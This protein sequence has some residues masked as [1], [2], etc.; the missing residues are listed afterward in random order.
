MEN[1][2]LRTLKPVIPKSTM[3]SI[4][5]WVIVFIATAFLCVYNVATSSFS[6][7]YMGTP[8]YWT[9]LGLTSLFMIII[10][11]CV[12]DE[13]QNKTLLKSRKIMLY[14]YQVEQAY[15]LIGKHGLS[16]SLDTYILEINKLTTYKLFLFKTNKK[17]ERFKRMS[18]PIKKIYAKFNID[19]EAKK[20]SLADD[21]K[22]EKDIVWESKAVKNAKMIYRSQLFGSVIGE[23]KCEDSYDLSP[24]KGA[25]L[26]N[27]VS[28]KLTK[29]ILFTALFGLLASSSFTGGFSLTMAVAMAAKIIN[30]LI[31]IIAARDSGIG[32]VLGN[33]AHACKSKHDL[34]SNFAQQ[35]DCQ[36]LKDILNTTVEEFKV[37]E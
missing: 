37:S 34:L 26:G 5:R 2:E 7:S 10:A 3:N 17:L 33:V 18:Q 30:I 27:L 35:E 28:R 21:L 36:E 29:P 19:L 14:N 4:F 13:Y 11:F 9:A 24:H 23:I 32:Y 16:N 15:S 1:K 20:A 22:L 31:T 6:L 8:E 12:F 25:V